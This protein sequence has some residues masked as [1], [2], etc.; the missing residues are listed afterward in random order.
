SDI[1]DWG[2]E[3]Y[4]FSR[5]EMGYF[6][7]L[8][9]DIAA[10]YNG[11]DWE[12]YDF[13]AYMYE[14]S[15]AIFGESLID[16]NDIRADDGCG[17]YVW[18]WYYFAYEM[19]DDSYCQVGSATVSNN[20]IWNEDDVGIWTGPYDSGECVYGNSVAV[21]GDYIVERNTVDTVNGD[22]I[23]FTYYYVG[24]DMDGYAS[25]TAG[26]GIVRDN[27]I[28][29]GDT[30]IYA[31]Y[32]DIAEDMWDHSTVVV[33]DLEV[34]GNEVT[35]ESYGIY[36]DIEYVGYEMYEDSMATIGSVYVEGN[37]ITTDAVFGTGIYAEIYETAYDLEHDAWFSIGDVHIYNNAVLQSIYG[38]N[39]DIDN[40]GET[41]DN[42]YGEIPGVYVHDCTFEATDTG[43]YIESYDNPTWQDP[44]STQVWG[45]V[46]IYD[47]VFNDGDG[48]YLE[49]N[50]FVLPDIWIHD[51]TFNDNSGVGTAVTAFDIGDA[52]AGVGEAL[53][54]HCTFTS[55]GVG[56]YADNSYLM[57]GSCVF[58]TFTGWDVELQNAANVFMV[59][60]PFDKAN[61]FYGDG[62]SNL[63][64][65]WYLTVNVVSQVGY[66]V[67]G[68][69]GNSFSLLPAPPEAFVTDANGQ[70]VLMLREYRENI[71]GLVWDYNPYNVSATKGSQSAWADPF[72]TMDMSKEITFT[73]IDAAPPTLGP[74]L[75]IPPGTTGD[76]FT[77]MIDATDDLGIYETLIYYRWGSGG[78]VSEP[79]TPG[80]PYAYDWTVP[81]DYV[82]LIEYY[83][84]TT[85]VGGNTVTSPVYSMISL[86][87][88][89]P[90]GAL[91]KSSEPITGKEFKFVVKGQDNVGATSAWVTY[92]FDSAPK[93]TVPMDGFGRFK[94]TLPWLIPEPP[95]TLYYY[96]V[97]EDD[98]GLSFT[99]SIFSQSIEEEKDEPPE[100]EEPQPAAAAPPAPGQPGRGG[101][102][103]SLASEEV[104]LFPWILVALLLLIILLLLVDRIDRNREEN[105]EEEMDEPFDS[106]EEPIDG[107]TGRPKGEPPEPMD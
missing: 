19:Y 57:I 1:C 16:G 95:G 56:I 47:C 94:Y 28:L 32:Y 86:D 76:L 23:Y 63:D 104:S 31:E 74:D 18:W 15:R 38:L 37:T 26:K 12:P 68:I 49:G 42:A 62:A 85:D 2:Y 73:F 87:N 53:I 3:M 33:G 25:V 51:C 41:Y 102:G 21:F 105:E 72:V 30:G 6:N 93:T 13:G 34:T 4:G 90:T 98:A 77:F 8:D 39:I 11:I 81:S 79:M 9:N 92:W 100:D 65:G 75:S 91:D 43:L 17:L 14:N 96:F 101:G 107:S 10:G 48:I 7:F 97:I 78:Y 36:L 44:F 83:F 55:Y 5:F 70:A 64:I 60:C 46:E 71:A 54:E 80:L 22:A 40:N 50:G 103:A 58:P 84:T 29:A 24:Y 61:V 45:P 99:S 52:F 82:G 89:P 59:D 69:L 66:G 106:V 88:D 35:A 67:P 20:E 27:I